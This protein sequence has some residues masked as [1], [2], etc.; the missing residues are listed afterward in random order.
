MS[1]EP[2]KRP[3][4]NKVAPIDAAAELD[5]LLAAPAIKPSLRFLGLSE[6]RS[7]DAER[8]ARAVVTV[9]PVPESTSASP[10][11][12]SGDAL[13][14]RPVPTSS[15]VLTSPPDLPP[16]PHAGSS[17]AVSLPGPPLSSP[18]SAVVLAPTDTTAPPA[19][20]PSHVFLSSPAFTPPAD[21]TAARRH[22]KIHRCLKA[23]D[24]HSPTEQIVYQIL[25]NSGSPL[26][27]GNRS[28][29]IGIPR[30]ARDTCI[31]ERNVP[32]ILRRLI[33][34]QSIDILKREISDQRTAR[35][36]VVF[37]YKDILE[38]RRKLGLEWVIRGRG[39]DFVNPNSGQPILPDVTR[40]YALSE[41]AGDDA[42]PAPSPAATPPETPAFP[43]RESPGAAPAK[44]PDATPPLL[45]NLG[46][47]QQEQYKETLS[48][49]SNRVILYEALAQYG[50]VDDDAITF[51][52]QTCTRISPDCTTDEIIHYVHIK[53][54]LSRRIKASNPIGFLLA[55]V[56]RCLT[57][58]A[59]Q[60]FRE[61]QRRIR[62]QKE[63]EELRLKEE[64]EQFREQQRAILA[65]AQASEEEKR[66]ARKMLGLEP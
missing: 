24:G 62:L 59:F 49:S 47:L 53:G 18:S 44:S 48:S 50:P 19:V 3:S 39:V 13:E 66:W 4:R 33:T 64:M 7:G 29:R 25:W 45:G 32:I 30:I 52:L 58:E 8:P 65:D 46:I 56:P 9:L 63:A 1:L 12:T 31:N 11:I 61:E 41:T 2:K 15:P 40:T 14:A 21:L 10:G 37:S 55:S 5:D 36:Y 26:P 57:G 35:T 60:R 27:D 16:A 22:K 28:V 54:D 42:E 17:Q 43:S 6:D 38:K 34:K 51:L 20:S 23:Q